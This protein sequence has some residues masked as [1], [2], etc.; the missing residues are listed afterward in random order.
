MSLLDRALIL[1][2]GA[3]FLA[4]GSPAVAAPPSGKRP[5]VILISLDGVSARLVKQ[6]KTPALDAMAAAGARVER[7]LPPF[8]S[9]TFPSHAT[10][11]TGVYPDKHGIINNKFFDRKRGNFDRERPASWLRVEPLWVTA[12]KQG[13]RAGIIMWVTSEGDWRGTLPSH[14][15]KFRNHTADD[16]K[17]ERIL[18]WLSLPEEERPGLIMAWFRGTD[19]EGHRFGPASEEAVLQLERQ[20]EL[21]GR[22][23]EGIARA[24]LSKQVTL[25]V[26]SDHGVVPLDQLVNLD[27]RLRSVGL[28]ARV[29]TTGGVSNIYLEAP[30]ERE[31][32]RKALSE[33]PEIS[34]YEREDLPREWRASAEGRLGDL[35][36][37]AQPG[38]AFSEDPRFVVGRAGDER[39]GGHG[40]PPGVPGTDGILFAAGPGIMKGARL[41]AAQGVDV[42]PTICA[43][44]GVRPA[45]RLDGH[46]LGALLEP[47]WAVVP[48]DAS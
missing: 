2:L 38:A 12:E 46:P 13:V 44:L 30:W 4:L 29:S 34:V 18:A 26:V 10:I 6:A 39:R 45:P 27:R 23:G 5:I 8:P 47:G 16:Q 15:M 37:V 41:A 43:I 24:G 9:N 31:R 40:Y 20:D 1:L 7:V 33:I 14:H 22:L 11:A 17:V 19:T 32:A 42:N 21:L 28:G 48:G 36:A 3:V 25:V 35:I